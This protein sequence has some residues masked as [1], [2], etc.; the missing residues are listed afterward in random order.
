M[1]SRF[2]LSYPITR[3]I[4]IHHFTLFVTL[5][6]L[7]L[8]VLITLLGLITV[9]YEYVPFLSASYNSTE[10]IW[11]DFLPKTTWTPKAIVCQGSVLKT[12]ECTNHCLESLNIALTTSGFV[13]YVMRSFVDPRIDQYD[14]MIYSNNPLQNCSVQSMTLSQTLSSIEDDTAEVLTKPENSLTL[15]PPGM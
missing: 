15:G 8:F 9:G 1:A 7:L 4:T 14:G 10:T 12:G 2:S 3:A 13:D 6:G 5:G 11:Y